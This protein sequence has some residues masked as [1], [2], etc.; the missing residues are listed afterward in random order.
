M[1]LQ[2]PTAISVILAA[3]IVLMSLV[4]HAC[5]SEAPDTTPPAQVTDLRVEAFTETTAVLIW[6][7]PGD[8]GDRGRAAEYDLRVAVATPAADWL[9]AAQADSA[10]APPGNAGAVD[11]ASIRGLVSGQAY[12]FA[13]RT[14]DTEANWSAF[15]NVVRVEPGDPAPP[16]RVADLRAVDLAPH[17][18]T[19]VFTA[20]GDDSLSGWAEEYAL[21]MSPSPIT[22][23]TW[24]QA[25]PISLCDPP[26]AARSEEH[27]RITALH[28]QIPVHLAI[29]ARDDAGRWS[30]VSNDLEVIP[31]SDIVAPGTITDLQVAETGTFAARLQWT[32]PGNDGDEAK[33]DGYDI[34]YA[35]S[36]IEDE[37]G[38][39]AASPAQ[40]TVSIV[41]PGVIQTAV[42]TGLPAPKTLWFAV[43]A[44]DF[45]GNRGQLSNGV[46]GYVK[47]VPRSWVI[48]VDGSGD[49]PTVQAGIDSAAAGDTVLVGPGTYYENITFGTKDLVVR[50]EMGPETTVLHGSPSATTVTSVREP[51]SL[52]EDASGGLLLSPESLIGTV[53]TIEG[54][55]S[56]DTIL[57]GFSVTGGQHGVVVLNSH[58]TI[59]GNR[60]FG[61]SSSYDGGGILCVG[62]SATPARP[63]VCGNS[64]SDNYV[65]GIGGGIL[66][67]NTIA[68]IEGNEILRNRVERGDGGGIYYVE[69][70]IGG[71][72]HDNLIQGNETGDQGGGIYVSGPGATRY[73]VIEGN[74]IYQNTARGNGFVGRS[75]GGVCL[76]DSNSEIV[77]NTIVE[78]SAPGHLNA[79]GGGIAV[80]YPGNNTIERNIIAYS[81]EGGGI[82]CGGG[83]APV[84]RN[85][86]AWE[87]SGGHGSGDCPTWWQG[88]GNVASDPMFCGRSIGD[89]SLADISPALTHPAGPLGAIPSAGCGA[90]ESKPLT[91]GRIS[92]LYH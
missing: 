10:M 13:L 65:F 28:P 59:R 47:R 7:A 5:S 43:R 4:M 51:I 15:S 48:R 91:W 30:A 42:L 76:T 92:T 32:A 86:L 6:T 54:G 39:T 53:V 83:T 25:D 66:C 50:S 87:N 19:L 37:A 75:G 52:G 85:N 61:N 88:D 11:R 55:Q 77:N 18:A 63:L 41:D 21:R 49:A 45:D 9:M 31:P 67:L 14:A 78:N 20:P 79:Y 74:I 1:N 17:A 60:I 24:D 34:R 3:G 22:E 56:R 8:D 71:V 57:E 44:T 16:A 12:Y 2:K 58:P 90:M 27:F 29:R 64:I 69:G 23:V 26:K 72:I 62:G 36:R 80:Y 89:F 33:V 84:I 38:W 68:E 70:A 46:S 73:V 35:E 82:L 40:A 81:Q